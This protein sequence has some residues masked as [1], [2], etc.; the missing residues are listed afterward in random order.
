MPSTV[1][2]LGGTVQRKE[3]G[4]SGNER[5]SDDETNDGSKLE[6]EIA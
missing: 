4:A 1:Y 2:V 5:D 6:G 3:D